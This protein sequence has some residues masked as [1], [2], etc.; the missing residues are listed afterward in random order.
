MQTKDNF[1]QN[2]CL[3]LIEV[4]QIDNALMSADEIDKKSIS[5]MGMKEDNQ[6]RP[7][8]SESTTNSPK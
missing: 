8:S 2:I 1:Y 7:L 6:K 5:L 4:A 3:A